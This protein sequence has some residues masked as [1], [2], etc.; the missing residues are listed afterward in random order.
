MLAA[1]DHIG[2]IG[3]FY[4][5]SSREWV[6]GFT[7]APPKFL[8]MTCGI[9]AAIVSVCECGP[10]QDLLIVLTVI[11]P[12]CLILI[13]KIEYIY[14]LACVQ[15]VFGYSLDDWAP[16][17]YNLNHACWHIS[18]PVTKLTSHQQTVTW[19]KHTQY[20]FWYLIWLSKQVFLLN[21]NIFIDFAKTLFAIISYI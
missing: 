3:T 10:I 15:I 4:I 1:G 7:E 11:I 2:I 9:K 17:L 8:S 13:C 5:L 14:I 12:N 6:S 18:Y 16:L 20:N 21:K 19:T